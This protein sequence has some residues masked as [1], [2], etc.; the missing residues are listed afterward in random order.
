MN[1]E[2]PIRSFEGQRTQNHALEDAEHRRVRADADCQGDDGGE[3]EAGAAGE[4][5]Q[6]VAKVVHSRIATFGCTEPARSAGTR[7]ARA[8]NAS[9]PTATT[10]YTRQSVALRPNKTTCIVRETKAAEIPPIT[11]P[12]APSSTASFRIK[13]RS[14]PG[15]APNARRT[16]NS[17]RR[18]RTSCMH[19]A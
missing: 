11:I 4:R 10:A 1:H 5:A 7:E 12:A 18:V 6:C 17:R 13:L 2:Q 19:I 9:T 14:E 15:V 16:P 3:R 8:A